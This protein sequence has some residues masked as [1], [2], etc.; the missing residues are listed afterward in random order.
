M[1]KR[2]RYCPKPIR[3]DVMSF[4]KAGIQTVAATGALSSLQIKNHDALASLVRGHANRQDIEMLIEASNM[5]EG[6]AWLGFGKQWN[7]AIKAGEDAIGSIASKGAAN[8]HFIGTGLELEALRELM[9]V[10]D[11]QLE[12]VTVQHME[13]AMDRVNEVKRNKRAREVTA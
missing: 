4:V 13:R 7:Q 5:T 11:A 6:L 8:S 9:S 3:Q 1:K 10:H 12:A 2:S